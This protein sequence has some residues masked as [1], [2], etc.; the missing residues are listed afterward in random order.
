MMVATR[1]I[2]NKK[3]RRVAGNGTF[4]RRGESNI[5]RLLA[6]HFKSVC[7]HAHK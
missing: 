4:I 3:G 7:G 6:F 1:K 5:R 2:K